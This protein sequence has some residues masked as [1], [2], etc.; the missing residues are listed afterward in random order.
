MVFTI[1]SSPKKL[2]GS[3]DY[4]E[5]R[6]R[7]TLRLLSRREQKKSRPVNLGECKEE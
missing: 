5:Y 7:E 1:F 4:L 6:Q 3:F 2:I